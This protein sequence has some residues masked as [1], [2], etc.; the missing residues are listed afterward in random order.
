MSNFRKSDFSI[1]GDSLFEFSQFGANSN[2][3][4]SQKLKAKSQIFIDFLNPRKY[5]L[6]FI[7][8]QKKE[9]NSS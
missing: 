6:I 2:M 5:K 1:F 9:N 3:E 7:I 8:F 4:F